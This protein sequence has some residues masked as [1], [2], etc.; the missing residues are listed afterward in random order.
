MTKL[1]EFAQR[2][3]QIAWDMPLPVSWPD[4]KTFTCRICIAAIRLTAKSE[5]Q[6][7]TEVAASEHIRKEH[8]S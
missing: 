2:F 3:P 5:H 1:D 7:P 4:R 8:M 6:W